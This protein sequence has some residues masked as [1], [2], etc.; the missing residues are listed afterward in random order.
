MYPPGTILEDMKPS[1]DSADSD[2]AEARKHA[3]GWSKEARKDPRDADTQRRAG[4]AHREAEKA[5]RA[6]HAQN[7][8]QLTLASANEHAARATEHEA[9]HQKLTAPKERTASSPSDRRKQAAK[10]ATGG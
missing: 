4:A 5:F 9:A 3:V 1:T 2:A 6:L 10:A 8:S 7:G